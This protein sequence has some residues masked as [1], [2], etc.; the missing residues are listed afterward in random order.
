MSFILPAQNYPKNFGKQA[1]PVSST[2][3]FCNVTH[4][5]LATLQATS[6]NPLN[7]KYVVYFGGNGQDCL[8]PDFIHY[9]LIQDKNRNYVFW[10]YPNVISSQGEVKSPKDLIQAG[11]LQVMR[12]IEQG[13]SAEDI[14]LNGASLGGGVAIA[15]ARRLYKEGHY[16]DLEI[17]RSFASLSLTVSAPI[18]RELKE[19]TYISMALG[20]G[21]IGMT[22]GA[23]VAGI[24]ATFGGFFGQSIEHYIHLIGSFIGAGI[25][26]V[27]GLA[28]GLLGGIIGFGLSRL[29][30]NYQLPLLPFIRAFLVV[31]SCEMDSVYEMKRLIEASK[32][33]SRRPHIQVVNTWDDEVIVKEASLIRGLDVGIENASKRIDFTWYKTGGH[34]A[35]LNKAHIFTPVF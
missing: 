23:L 25:A 32:K 30:M 12:V 31:T 28:L 35:M 34:N 8:N 1:S 11:Y 5:G 27:T 14:C 21:L 26:I 19:Q 33:A 17:D 13:I 18:D 7:S 20:F 2:H 10:N 24:I 16:V 4:H 9:Q 3:Y 22:L 29:N 15:V 6:F